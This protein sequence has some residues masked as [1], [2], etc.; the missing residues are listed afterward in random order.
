[1]ASQC[2]NLNKGIKVKSIVKSVI[3]L[4][5]FAIS[6]LM[7]NQ[8]KLEGF[9]FSGGVAIN[10]VDGEKISFSVGPSNLV[11]D[12]GFAMKLG[13]GY[14]KLLNQNIVVGCKAGFMFAGFMFDKDVIQDLHSRFSNEVGLYLLGGYELGLRVGM[15]I[16]KIMPYAKIAYEYIGISGPKENPITSYSFS[17]SGPGFGF[18]YQLRDNVRLDFDY[19][20]FFVR[21]KLEGRTSE[22]TT[23]NTFS[24]NVNIS[25]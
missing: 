23:N 3:S 19:T 16:E 25:L 9:Y 18:E 24:L 8:I 20:E 12:T 11:L 14:D 7:A 2:S 5:I 13:M 1:M 4:S 6:T 17:G 22:S 21:G 15:K 10:S